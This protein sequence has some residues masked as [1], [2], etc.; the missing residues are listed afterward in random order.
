MSGTS[1]KRVPGDYL[2]FPGWGEEDYDSPVSED[3]EALMAAFFDDH[4][5]VK[6]KPMTVEDILKGYVPPHLRGKSEMKEEA[7][8]EEKPQ[9]KLN[10]I[11]GEKIPN[12]NAFR[13]CEEIARKENELCGLV[14]RPV[15]K[16]A[17]DRLAII[18]MRQAIVQKPDENV[19]QYKDIGTHDD[20]PGVEI[21]EQWVQ[22]NIQIQS[23]LPVDRE[24]VKG[25]NER[26]R[27][28]SSSVAFM[29]HRLKGFLPPDE[30][31]YWGVGGQRLNK[32]L[33]LVFMNDY[34]RKE[35]RK[36]AINRLLSTR[37]WITKS[38]YA[39]D[40]FSGTSLET[41]LQ[42]SNFVA[43]LESNPYPKLY[44]RMP[45]GECHLYGFN[46]GY[47]FLGQIKFAAI[48]RNRVA[49]E[50]FWLPKI[51][52]RAKQ[53]SICVEADNLG[54]HG[55]NMHCISKTMDVE[56]R[57]IRWRYASPISVSHLISEIE[58][59]IPVDRSVLGKPP[60]SC[61]Y[62]YRGWKPG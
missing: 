36:V 30:W 12:K 41:F 27:A 6:S 20:L 23:F 46:L 18:E 53:K 2:F 47:K 60:D 32:I 34:E 28:L 39:I 49:N 14:A 7:K 31:N 57:H 17:L 1:Q 43:G 54:T 45:Y 19:V 5:G 58:K 40:G 15:G 21:T 13:L 50:P 10:V 38:I 22:D 9:P 51:Q 37:W 42:G 56:S 24:Y 29:C 35:E 26:L 16:V 52:S 33:S 11:V 62:T 55:I 4:F 59:Q 8:V 61:L 44:S 25:R 3:D 48:L